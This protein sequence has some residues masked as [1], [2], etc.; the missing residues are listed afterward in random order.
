MKQQ[1][2][3]SVFERTLV[4]SMGKSLVRK[5]EN[6]SDAQQLYIELIDYLKKST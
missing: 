3:Y 2:M 1:F 5:H 6:D 4:T